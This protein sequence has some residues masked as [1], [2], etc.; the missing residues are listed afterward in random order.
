MR[1][2]VS[3]IVAVAVAA[4]LPVAL[5]RARQDGVLPQAEFAAA[6]DAAECGIGKTLPDLP[7]IDLDGKPGRLSDYA[8]KKALV[9]VLRDVGCP[10]SKKYGLRTAEIEREYGA[11]DVAFLYV[12][13]TSNDD[14]EE[15]KEEVAKYGFGG[16]YALELEGRFGWHLKVRSTCDAFVLD[17]ARTLRYRGPIDDQ[18]GRGATRVEVSRH[19]LKEAIDAVL[20]GAA[21]ASPALTAP[22][23]LLSFTVEPPPVPES[24]PASAPPAAATAPL[25]WFGRIEAIAQQRCQGCH[26]SGGPG[27]FELAS[28]EDFAGAATMVAKA[29]EA[30][31]MPPWFAT[32]ASGPFQHDPQLTAD[33]KRDLLQWI[34]EGCA[35]GDPALALPPR[36]QVSGWAIGEPDLVVA[37]PR[38]IE[39]PATG[40]VDYVITDAP[41]GL[42]EDVWVEA[43][44]I[45]CAHPTICHHVLAHAFYPDVH[46]QEFVDSYLPGREATFFPPGMAMQLGKGAVIRF[47]LHYTP[48]G[49]PVKERTRIGFKFAKEKPQF[50]VNGQIVRSYE[51]DI[52]P[53][54]PNYSVV[55]EFR[56]PTDATI[57]RLVPHMHLRG[58]SFL[59]ELLHPDGSTSVPLELSRWDPDWQYA[60]EFVEPIA[61]Q[62]GTLVRCT[63]WY[64]NSAANPLNP[65]PKKRVGPGQQIWD[66][67]AGAFVE[68]YR[69]ADAPGA[70]DRKPR[71]PEKARRARMRL[72]DGRRDDA[73]D[74]ADD[75]GDGRR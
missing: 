56:F 7:F 53:G 59:L 3:V 19:F 18:I 67:M 8:A 26:F 49:T 44:Q 50:R 36:K 51:I 29:V 9:I 66:E 13:P 21:V 17:P 60:Y 24:A 39:I 12:N 72:G 64:D 75:D 47:N 61:V 46:R 37:S 58:K 1:L 16:R 33:E 43:I 30:G 57:R 10:V 35:A 69:P 27:P 4:L 31:I 68:W 48:D 74:D 40:V 42:T 55:S 63:N 32:S 28:A 25:R 20:A 71:D 70:R 65:D 62:R 73:A 6:L 41:T 11:R 22:G 45:L 34:A 23:C 52:P 5:G 38:A 14:V 15:C 2:V 54:A